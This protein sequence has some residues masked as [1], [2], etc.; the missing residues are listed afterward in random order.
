MIHT[1][2]TAATLTYPRARVLNESRSNRPPLL[3]DVR[4]SRFYLRS[5]IVMIY[6]TERPRAIRARAPLIENLYARVFIR[7]LTTV[8]EQ[9]RFRPKR[10]YGGRR[11][12]RTKRYYWPRRPLTTLSRNLSWRGGLIEDPLVGSL[13]VSNGHGSKGYGTLAEG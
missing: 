10:P 6:T 3:S 9:N 5:N 7:R 8:T 2:R 4:S 1:R 12:T 13:R 11:T